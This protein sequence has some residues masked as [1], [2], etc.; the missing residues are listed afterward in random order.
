MFHEAMQ[1]DAPMIIIMQCKQL[2]RSTNTSRERERE[3][4]R[5]RKE[6]KEETTVKT[7]HCLRSEHGDSRGGGSHRCRR[8][9]NG[10]RFYH[11]AGCML[12]KEAHRRDEVFT[13]QRCEAQDLVV[14]VESGINCTLSI[15]TG[16]AAW[17]VSKCQNRAFGDSILQTIRK[18]FVT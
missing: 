4:E 2:N 18:Q 14:T 16:G 15:S 6:R 8:H 9:F 12:L 13:S 3:R 10:W 1:R 17:F 11:R 7:T 5:E